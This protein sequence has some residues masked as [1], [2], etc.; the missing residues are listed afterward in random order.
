[1]RI[2]RLQTTN[3]RNLPN[4][5]VA[6][7]RNTVVVGENKSGKSNLV[8]ALRLVLDPTL[9][10]TERRLTTDDFWDGLAQGRLGYDPME[11]K[12]VIEVAVE[13]DDF[14]E[15]ERLLAVL[16]GGLI[17][18]EPMRAR[19][20]YRW[21]PDAT[22][23][24]AYRDGVYFGAD[25]AGTRVGS[26][27]RDELFVAFLHAL[28]DVEN[29][30][31]SW[32]KSPLR[33]LLDAAIEKLSTDQ[34]ESIRE[35]LRSSNDELQAMDPIATIGTKIAQ[36]MASSVGSRQSLETSLRSTPQDPQRI[37]RSMQLY[38][39]GDSARPLGATSL[40]A[41]NVLYFTLLKLGF[42][43]QLEDKAVSHTVILAEEPEAHLHPQVQRSLLHS[44][45][46]DEDASSLLVT[47]HSPHIAS[48][49]DARD[50][51][52]LNPSA[53]GTTAWAAS[54]AGLSEPEWD[55]INRYL[56]A[57]RAEMVFAS[58]VLL[59]EGYGEQVV[60]PALARQL[61]LDLDHEGITVCAIHGT[62]FKSFVKFCDALGIAWAVLTDGDI[63]GAGVSQGSLRVAALQTELGLEGPPEEN[64]LFMG[65]DTLEVDL[66]RLEANRVPM[67]SVLKELGSV[68]AA[69]RIAAWNGTPT[70]EQLIG[71]VRNAGGKGRVNQRLA[72]A[73]L[74]P[75]LH[76]AAALEYLGG[77]S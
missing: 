5:D 77:L 31:R 4:L 12:Q 13:I 53:E 19:L 6:L 66:Y 51:V 73:S 46:S 41:Q 70:K 10:A 24:D 1:M 50:L 22:K 34:L 37:I 14:E 45:R 38:V 3:F 32:R 7:G 60:V 16:S 74:H 49:T 57:T 67:E 71:E 2:T 20:T 28:R 44:L 29:D 52:R 54:S 76:V 63:D 18:M 26:D 75:P 65:P 64:G 69:N 21:A 47:T 56:D 55:D 9:P 68:H 43:Q 8:R 42:A 25:G 33:V 61:G 30:I 27:L 36:L 15:D 72:D 40:G 35:S 59:V 17:S 23:G 58:R 48:A 11:D 62:H 39:D